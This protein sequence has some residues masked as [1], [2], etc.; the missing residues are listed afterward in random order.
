MLNG[1]RTI[2]NFF[3][4]KNRFDTRSDPIIKMY[5]G[6]VEISLKKN[7]ICQRKKFKILM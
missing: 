7:L 1:F 3:L 6:I 2:F 5:S 4:K